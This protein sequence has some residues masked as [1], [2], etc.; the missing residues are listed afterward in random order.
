M[1]AA[2]LFWTQFLG[3]LARR[4]LRG[5]KRLGSPCDPALRIAPLIVSLPQP[6]PGRDL[7]VPSHFRDFSFDHLRRRP[8]VFSPA[9]CR[10]RSIPMASG[11]AP[12]VSRPPMNVGHRAH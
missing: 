10:T 6:I 1:A 11:I 2:K 5:V 3:K 12:A 4:G 9:M 7:P 8:L